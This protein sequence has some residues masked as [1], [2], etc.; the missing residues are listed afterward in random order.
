MELATLHYGEAWAF[1]HIGRRSPNELPRVHFVCPHCKEPTVAYVRDDNLP[2]AMGDTRGH[3]S[4]CERPVRF[5]LEGTLGERFIR[6]Q[7][8]REGLASI[9]AEDRQGLMLAL[10]DAYSRPLSH[11]HRAEIDAM[12]RRTVGRHPSSAYWSDADVIQAFKRVG[13]R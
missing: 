4:E 1:C 6:G 3:C 10:E 2:T 5:R 9:P 13:P 11:R 8:L 7:V 12:S